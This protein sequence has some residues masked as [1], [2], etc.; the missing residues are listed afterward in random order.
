MH[1]K[2][3]DRYLLLAW[4]AK[5]KPKDRNCLKNLPDLATPRL[6]SVQVSGKAGKRFSNTLCHT[7]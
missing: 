7:H 1:P 6:R 4:I 2:S 5:S 3:H